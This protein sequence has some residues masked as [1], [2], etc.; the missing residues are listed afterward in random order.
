M[1]SIFLGR[2]TVVGYLPVH[3][4]CKINKKHMLSIFLGRDAVFGYLP[5]YTYSLLEKGYG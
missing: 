2:G 3:L 1:L 4:L 5:V